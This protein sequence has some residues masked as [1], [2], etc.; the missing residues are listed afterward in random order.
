MSR[1]IFLFSRIKKTQDVMQRCKWCRKSLFTRFKGQAFEIE[2]ESSHYLSSKRWKEKLI[3]KL[4]QGNIQALIALSEKP[5]ALYKLRTKLFTVNFH[6]LT[7]NLEQISKWLTTTV[8]TD[9]YSRNKKKTGESSGVNGF[10]TL[11][12]Y[13]MQSDLHLSHNNR[14]PYSWHMRRM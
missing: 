10:Y 14:Q 7:F 13:K 5:E 1:H 2:N 6:I 12:C 9:G 11:I 4:K 3:F 8:S